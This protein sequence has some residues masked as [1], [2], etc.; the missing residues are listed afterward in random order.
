MLVRSKCTSRENRQCTNR[1]PT[2][3]EQGTDRVSF[4]GTD[5][6][7]ARNRQ[8][9]TRQT[10]L[11]PR[12]RRPLGVV[13]HSDESYV[14]PPSLFHPLFNWAKFASFRTGTDRVRTTNRQSTN[15]CYTMTLVKV[16]Q[17]DSAGGLCRR[18]G[19]TGWSYLARCWKTNI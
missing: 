14:L 1:E 5:R 16:W 19:P 6:N 9:I 18:T 2:E 3:Y 8:F 11:Q 10:S 4:Q 12:L 17:D 7:R 15:R 13:S